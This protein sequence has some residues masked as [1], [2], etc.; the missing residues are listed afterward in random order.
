[1]YGLQD[2]PPWLAIPPS[3][4]STPSTPHPT[5]NTST[6]ATPD[7]PAAPPTQTPVGAIVGGVVGS[8]ALIV[9]LVLGILYF[10]RR[11]PTPLPADPP[12][13]ELA[14]HPAYK[15]PPYS[16]G[17]PTS[18]HYPSGQFTNYDVQ[19]QPAAYVPPY[20]LQQLQNTGVDQRQGT[21]GTPSPHLSTDDP[22]GPSSLAQLTRGLSEQTLTPGATIVDLEDHTNLGM[23]AEEVQEVDTVHPF[24]TRDNRAE[25]ATKEGG[26]VK[27]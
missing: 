6:S 15:E 21:Q 24:G 10:R 1:V 14:H 13:A 20:S 11:T 22:L 17:S 3:Q 5:L 9:I 12:I 2:Y 27:R 19:Q 23:G 18:P 26:E 25:L 8:F 7:L 4:T 16:P